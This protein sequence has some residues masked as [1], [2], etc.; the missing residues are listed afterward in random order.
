[1]NRKIY[2]IKVLTPLHVG[3]GQGLSHV[4]LPIVREVHTGFPFVPGSSIKGSLRELALRRLKEIYFKDTD[5]K[6]STLDKLLSGTKDKEFEETR[7]K[8]N[9][10]EDFEKELK[11]LMDIFG[12]AGE[13]AEGGQGG[14]G[15]VIFTD[16]RLLF[17]PVKSL[18]SVFML[19]T[20]PLAIKRFCEDLQLDENT[21]FLEGI[22]DGK[23]LTTS[24]KH[25]VENKVM[26]EEFVFDANKSDELRNFFNKYYPD[27]IDKIVCVSD[28]IFSD[29]VQNYT[30]VQTHVKINPDTGTVDEGALW[31]TEYLPAESVLYFSLFSMKKDLFPEV[32]SVFHLGGDITTG[33]G[34]VKKVMEV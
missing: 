1:M 24:D 25:L 6:L 9:K 3:A 18:K 19:I 20:C 31:T 10:P 23:A 27:Q 26:L 14:S 5:V 29:F 17:F 2:F 12:T 7:N 11:K 15:K 21:S 13:G 22:D 4:D 8:A 34:F 28:T 32:P 33:K 16:A 30:E